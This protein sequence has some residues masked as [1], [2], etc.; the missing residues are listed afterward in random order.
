MCIRDRGNSRGSV[1]AGPI[2]YG[3]LFEASAYEHQVLRMELTGRELL[4]LQAQ[5]TSLDPDVMLAW[6]GLPPALHPRRTYTVA[7]NELLV[8]GSGD[9]SVLRRGRRV[10]RM[11][12]D[13][14]A[15]VRYVQ[16][17]GAVG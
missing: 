9:F 11:G 12:T 3:E 15:L 2:T 13:L 17:E 16:A 6:S 5:Q 1:D 10:R 4:A 14:E 7:A 8:E